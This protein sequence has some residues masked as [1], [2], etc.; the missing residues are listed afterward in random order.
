MVGA[1]RCV[2]TET[3]LI[4]LC[5]GPVESLGHL[6]LCRLDRLTQARHQS[7]KLL[8]T[9]KMMIL[10]MYW[11]C[12]VFTIFWTSK[13]KMHTSTALQQSCTWSISNSL[14]DLLSDRYLHLSL[15]K[16][17]LPPSETDWLLRETTALSVHLAQTHRSL[18]TWLC[19]PTTRRKCAF[20]RGYQRRTS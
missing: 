6:P 9:G 18:G 17:C 5:T 13:P 8:A 15:H 14:L 12:W 3:P 20:P 19:R 1:W 2:E 10:S 16:W 4:L 11:T 7:I